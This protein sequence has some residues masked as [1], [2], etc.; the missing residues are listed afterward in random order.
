VRHGCE[1]NG[2]QSL[3]RVFRRLSLKYSRAFQRRV[4]VSLP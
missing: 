4:N 2:D 3:P 1:M